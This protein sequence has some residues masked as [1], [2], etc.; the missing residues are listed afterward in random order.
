[1]ITKLSAHGVLLVALFVSAAANST[2]AAQAQT[3]RSRFLAVV[4]K[5]AVTD[6]VVTMET[7]KGTF[8]LQ[9]YKKDAPITSANFID[10][11]QKGF[12][13][14]IT[15]HRYEPGFAIQGGDPKADGTGGY[16]DPVTHQE[17]R[18][19]LEVKPGNQKLTHSAAGVLG[20]ARAADPNSA[21]SQFYVTLAPA[22]GLD[23]KYTVFG[24][25]SEGLEVAM[26]LRKGDKILRATVVEP[27]SK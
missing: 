3:E 27:P 15:F 16:V 21:S 14:G 9:V 23:G 2:T 1:M 8:K 13:N 26:A 20:M 12:Y 18:I 6:P 4:K 19:P 25:V 17:R 11:V 24:K 7:S 5:E 10:L 22:A